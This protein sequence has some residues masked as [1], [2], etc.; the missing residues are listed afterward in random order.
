MLDG[1]APFR[2]RHADIVFRPERAALLVLDM[3]EYFLREGS[4]AFIPS[5]PAILPNLQRLI[6][7]FTAHNRPVIFTRH[8][9]TDEDARMMSRWWRDLIRADSPDSAISA[10][11]D[12]SKGIVIQKAQYDAFYNT[13]L[14]ETLRGRGVEQVIV[15]GVMTHLCC[16]TTARSAFVRGFEVFFCADGTATYTKELH[17]STLLNLSHGVAIPTVCAEIDFKL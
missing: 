10:S 12:I 1:L 6:S 15:T 13:P 16:E 17:R 3:Q 7:D 14:E 11:L 5:A 4:H 9:N 8:V 2:S